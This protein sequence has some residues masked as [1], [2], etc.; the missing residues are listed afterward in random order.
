MFTSEDR[1]MLRDIQRTLGLLGRVIIETYVKVASMADETEGLRQNIKD[2]GEQFD[3]LLKYVVE[4]DPEKQQ[5]RRD[6]AA[7]VERANMSEADKAQLKSDIEARFQESE[8]VENKMRD[9]IRGLPPI[10]GTPLLSTYPDR[11]QFDA[12]VAGYT[13]SERVTLDGADVKP[14]SD[15][16]IDYFT[17]NDQGGVI[18]RNGPAS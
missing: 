12:A 4:G 15:P 7:A 17:H 14:G 9:A 8:A 5:L 16:A 18:D 10:G 13:G 11:A 3:L 2:M 1:R 6:L